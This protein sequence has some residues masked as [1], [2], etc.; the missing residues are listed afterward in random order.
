[1]HVRRT[2]FLIAL[3]GG[4]A[5]CGPKPDAAGGAATSVEGV[6]GITR[7]DTPPGFPPPRAEDLAKLVVTVQGDRVTARRQGE[8]EPK[9]LVIELDAAASPKGITFTET[10][11]TWDTGPVGTPAAPR[12]KIKGIYAADGDTAKLAIDTTPDAP[13]PTDFIAKDTGTGAKPD[14]NNPPT[15]PTMVM[16]LHLK[17][18][19]ETP[20]WAK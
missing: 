9:Y 11:D 5:G 1:M 3:A 18:L 14:P 20:G 6:W 7:I 19:K 12:P 15:L 2:V 17:R 8:K 10:D 16:V 13:P 4:L